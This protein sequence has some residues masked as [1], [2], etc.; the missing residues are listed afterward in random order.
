MT[1]KPYKTFICTFFGDYC[2]K[3]IG[4]KQPCHAR[5]SIKLIAK[6]LLLKGNI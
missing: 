2:I 5:K 4:V 1:K 6:E 3:C